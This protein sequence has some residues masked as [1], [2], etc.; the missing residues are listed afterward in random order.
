MSPIKES[1]R[2]TIESLSD[3]EA[4]RLLEFI[5]SLREA[6]EARKP[7]ELLLDDPALR[8]PPA[9]CPGFRAVEALRG[10]GVPASKLLVGDRR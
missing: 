10:K 5:R 6:A 1:L 4:R 9:N 2:R 8:P 3:E 7:C